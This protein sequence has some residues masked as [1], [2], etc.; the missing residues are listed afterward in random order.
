ME[1]AASLTQSPLSTQDQAQDDLL[2]FQ[3]LASMTKSLFVPEMSDS[4]A[5]L[6]DTQISC[7]TEKLPSYLQSSPWKRIFRLDQD[8]CSLITFFHK[9]ADYDNTIIVCRDENGYVFGGFCTE[10][11]R[12]AYKF[13]GNFQMWLFTFEDQQEDCKVFQWQGDHEQFMYAD[14]KSIGMGGTPIQ[15]RFA[16]YLSQDLYRGSSLPTE[17]FNNCTLSKSQDFKCYKL[18]VWAI[19]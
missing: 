5:I 3:Q 12:C 1:T 6:T 17:T 11:W 8:G 15:G 9:C 4:S 14:D 18:E 7:L 2:L 19:D 13:F 16:F 10:A